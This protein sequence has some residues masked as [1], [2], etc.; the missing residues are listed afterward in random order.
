MGLPDSR[1]LLTC[2]ARFRLYS[3]SYYPVPAALVLQKSLL[4]ILAQSNNEVRSQIDSALGHDTARG[5]GNFTELYAMMLQDFNTY[6]PDDIL[7]KVD[8][9]SMY[10]SLE[11]IGP[12]FWRKY[13][14]GAKGLQ[15]VDKR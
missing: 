9:A 1:G 6:L 15:L 12:R 13:Q 2:W 5:H 3:I 14:M 4:R 8:R 7:C 11:T 10:Y